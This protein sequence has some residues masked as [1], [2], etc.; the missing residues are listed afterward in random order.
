MK[1]INMDLVEKLHWNAADILRGVVGEGEV[2]EIVLKLYTLKVL[3]DNDDHPY[4]I[5][6]SAK[7]NNLSSSGHGLGYR[8]SQTITEIEL[9]NPELRDL[10]LESKTGFE[11]IQD[12][13]LFQLIQ[14]F[15]RVNLNRKLMSEPDPLTGELAQITEKL[16]ETQARSEGKAAGEFSTPK[17]LSFLLARLLNPK[18]GTVYDGV[19][20]LG[21]F[22]IEAAKAANKENVSLYGQEI[23]FSTWVKCRLNLILHG[24]YEA[25][26][27]HGDTIRQPGWLDENR[28]IK[29][30]DYILMN[31]PMSLRNWGREEAE[32]DL[33]GRF[34][35]GIP[36][37]NI[38][39]MAFVQHAVA[40]MSE[41]GK[42]A[43]IVPPGV[44]IR[45]G[46]EQRIRS[47]LLNE[48]L[49]DAVIGLPANMM[50]GTGLSVVVLIFN[51]IKDEQRKGKV[52]IISAENDYLPGRI[53]NTL[54]K[55]DIEK[56]VNA[57]VN[58]EELEHYSRFVGLDE[59]RINDWNL[60]IQRYFETAEVET[61]IGKARISSKIYENNDIPKVELRAIAELFRGVLPPKDQEG[62]LNYKI[63][64]LS[65]VQDGKIIFDSLTY[66]SMSD[67]K[68][69]Y[70]YE[71]R[72]GDLLLASRGTALKIAVVP[73]TDE[74][75]ILSN[76]FICIR[77]K[78]NYDPYFLKY[79][80]ESPVGVHYLKANQRGAAVTVLSTKDISLIPVPLL[81]LKEQKK[82]AKSFQQADKE[83]EEAIELARK[84]HED[85]YQNY[86][87]Q[88]GIAGSIEIAD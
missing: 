46:A 21:S 12:R 1:K 66:V 6:P 67:F 28:S 56:I 55:E 15:D 60:N 13:V 42:A 47:A 77:T 9:L 70:R 30:F 75:L 8:L 74:N 16:F 34:R 86:Y 29:K 80:L 51:K 84:K 62:E 32:M 26:V 58:S 88:M 23:N 36:S 53:Q 11:K 49:I 39:D 82:I 52:Q 24:L 57:Y 35:Y 17:E 20:G 78:G 45:G 40:S 37:A 68:K 31:P 69:A 63:I 5:P 43:L 3:S 54:R 48:D 72:P 85:N 87:Q 50:L 61:K 7:W 71:V 33:Y 38:G 27:V 83:L 79:F 44:L 76:N 19:A 41:K 65:D 81:P 10:F 22:L 64:N 4:K 2:G 73:E 59:I 25:K 18:H 14:Q